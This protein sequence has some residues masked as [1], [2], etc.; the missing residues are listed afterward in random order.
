MPLRKA[1]WQ[2]YGKAGLLTLGFYMLLIIGEGYTASVFAQQHRTRGIDVLGTSRSGRPGTLLFDG[3]TL[4]NEVLAAAQKATEV[5]ISLPPEA[6]GDPFFHAIAPHALPLCKKVLYLSTIGVYGDQRGAWINENGPLNAKA[7]RALWRIKAE[8]QWLQSGVERGI[9]SQIFRL[10]GIY[11][12]GR[13]PLVDLAL[14]SAKRIEKPGQVFNRIHVED[15]A[16]VLL[17]AIERGEAGAIYNVVD[18]EPAAPQTVVEHACRLSG[19][20]LP[21]LTAFEQAALSPMARAF[22][23]DNRRVS[24]RKIR[25]ELGVDLAFPTYREGLCG[26]LA[27]GEYGP[28]AASQR[29]RDRTNV[30]SFSLS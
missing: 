19:A 1:V 23:A 13:N 28:G 8:R 21:P 7:E 11:G 29:A 27:A 30:Q 12:P 16:R 9:S 5:L 25:R 20:P 22:Y 24:N 14:G 10:G 3:Q 2:C 18:D 15:I 6:Q 4:S 26:L 17:A